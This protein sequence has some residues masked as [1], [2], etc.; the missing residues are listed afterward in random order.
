MRF[1]RI[2]LATSLVAGTATAASAQEP[3]SAARAGQRE[4]ARTEIRA[5]LRAQRGPARG[6]YRMRLSP[7]FGRLRMEMDRAERVRLRSMQREFAMRDR[8][9]MRRNEELMRQRD[10][11]DRIMDRVRARMDRMRVERMLLNR[12]RYRVI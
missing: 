11:R 3:D 10:A 4:R 2:L 9:L 1:R 12:K 6:A 7:D 8:V 5:L